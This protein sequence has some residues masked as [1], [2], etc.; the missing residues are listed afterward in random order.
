[1]LATTTMQ[2]VTGSEDY[3]RRLSRM[4]DV[5]LDFEMRFDDNIGLPASS[6]LMR[7]NSPRASYVDCHSGA[8]LALTQAARVI[9]DPRLATVIDRGLASYGLDTARVSYGA[10]TDTI[11]VLMVD[12]N[13]GRHCENAF[14]NFK[15]GIT[16]R[17]FNALRGSED[18]ALRAVAARH[19]ERM[20]LFETVIR[21]QLELSLAA[22]DD[23]IE[24]RCSLNSAETNSESQPWVMLGLV[25]HPCD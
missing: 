3:R 2:R 7:K 17:F 12:E 1:L 15:A 13:G 8:L 23:G 5:L 22:H 6:F 25:G 21:R 19:Q 10:M 16:L 14:W 9:A 11:S 20:Q 18:A 4:C 24:I